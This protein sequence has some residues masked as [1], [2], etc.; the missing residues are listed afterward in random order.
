MA[1]ASP[2]VS[3]S[4]VDR[5]VTKLAIWNQPARAATGAPSASAE[6]LLKQ[7]LEKRGT[8][9]YFSDPSVEFKCQRLIGSPGSFSMVA[10]ALQGGRAPMAGQC[11]STIPGTFAAVSSGLVLIDDF[12]IFFADSTK[13]FHQIHLLD[14]AIVNSEASP[15]ELI[16]ECQSPFDSSIAAETLSRR[17]GDE[18]PDPAAGSGA[19]DAPPA[20]P[21]APPGTSINGVELP[22]GG[23]SVPASQTT[24]H[25]FIRF[26]PG[27]CDPFIRV[28]LERFYAVYPSSPRLPFSLEVTPPDRLAVLKAHLPHGDP[29]DFA[30]SYRASCFRFPKAL[31]PLQSH[32]L[33]LGTLAAEEAALAA[34]ELAHHAAQADSASYLDGSE[35]P[36]KLSSAHGHPLLRGTFRMGRF[37]RPDLD[38]DTVHDHMAALLWSLAYSRRWSSLTFGPDPSPELHLAAIHA[39]G[40]QVPRSQFDPLN[41]RLDFLAAAGA[42][43]GPAV[44]SSATTSDS[45]SFEGLGASIVAL[46]LGASRTL[47]MAS[48]F[49]PGILSSDGSEGVASPDHQNP[50]ALA[51]E[52]ATS[53]PGAPLPALPLRTRR[54]R[55][56]GSSSGSGLNGA[57]AREKAHAAYLPLS[58]LALDALAQLMALGDRTPFAYIEASR[59]GLTVDPVELLAGR[60]R[61]LHPAVDGAGSSVAIASGGGGG[62]GGSGGGGVAAAV[63][64]SPSSSMT[65]FSP[66]STS[67]RVSPAD[68]PTASELHSLDLSG[69]LLCDRALTSL[70]DYL[71]TCGISLRGLAISES[72][73]NPRGRGMAALCR[74][75]LLLQ[76]A[77]LTRL[78]LRSIRLDRYVLSALSPVLRAAVNLERLDIART[79]LKLEYVVEDFSKGCARS[80]KYLDISENETSCLK[81]LSDII[82]H[83]ENL[84]YLDMS[85]NPLSLDSLPVFIRYLLVNPCLADVC[86]VLRDVGLNAE[87]AELIFGLIS[88][89][90]VALDIS[91]NFLG[92]AGLEAVAS[93]LL[94][95]SSS[96]RSLVMDRCFGAAH[97]PGEHGR[98]RFGP[99]TGGSRSGAGPPAP[100]S[101]PAQLFAQMLRSCVASDRSDG[102]ATA[103]SADVTQGPCIERLSM[104]GD[105]GQSSGRAGACCL[106][107][108]LVEAIL[109]ALRFN[110]S[111]R[112]V[113]LSGHAGEDAA[114]V[115]LVEVLKHNSTLQSVSLDNNGSTMLGFEKLLTALE[116]NH[117]LRRFPLPVQDILAYRAAT[118][119]AGG[120]GGQITT[121][122]KTIH[123]LLLRNSAQG[124]SLVQQRHLACRSLDRACV[125]RLLL[126]GVSVRLCDDSLAAPLAM[127]SDE[128]D[129]TPLLARQTAAVLCTDLSL[130]HVQLR[131][132]GEWSTAPLLSIPVT[133]LREVT[134]L[135]VRTLRPT[136]SEDSAGPGPDIVH[137]VRIDIGPASAATSSTG[138]P[139]SPVS[140]VSPA[141]PLPASVL[142]VVPGVSLQADVV[143]LLRR[144]RDESDALHLVLPQPGAAARARATSTSTS[145]AT[146]QS[147]RYSILQSAAPR[148]AEAIDASV[149]FEGALAS[150]GAP[151]V[152]R[153]RNQDLI[154]DRRH[155]IRLL[156][157]ARASLLLGPDTM[158]S[159]LHTPPPLSPVSPSSAGAGP[160]AARELPNWAMS[161]LSH[162]EQRARLD[163]A[164]PEAEPAAA[165]AHEQRAD[166]ASDFLRS[167]RERIQDYIPPVSAPRTFLYTLKGHSVVRAR[168]IPEL[169]VS[170]LNEGDA[171]VLIIESQPAAATS[172]PPAGSQSSQYRAFDANIY[173]WSGRRASRRERDA[174][175]LFARDVALQDYFSANIITVSD[176]TAEFWQTL[177]GR[178]ADVTSEYDAGL[179]A[180]EE[181][182]WTRAYTLLRVA[183]NP[184]DSDHASGT[185]VE[186]V[187]ISADESAQAASGRLRPSLDPGAAYVLDTEAGEVF[188]WVG[189]R[190]PTVLRVTAALL[191]VD[192]AEAFVERRLFKRAGGSR[193]A[194]VTAAGVSPTRQPDSRRPSIGS[195]DSDHEVNDRSADAPAGT[196]SNGL[197]SNTCFATVRSEV[198]GR[199]SVFWRSKF[200]DWFDSSSLLS[201]DTLPQIREHV[202]VLATFGQADDFVVSPT[203]REAPWMQLVPGRRAGAGSIQ[204]DSHSA[205]ISLASA[206]GRVFLVDEVEQKSLDVTRDALFEGVPFTT[207]VPPP[208]LLLFSEDCLFF[209]IDES[210]LSPE[211]TLILWQGSQTTRFKRKIARG[212]IN[213]FQLAGAL[214]R[215][216]I[217]SQFEEPNWFTTFIGRPLVYRRG[218]SHPRLTFRH[219]PSRLFRVPPL[220]AGTSGSPK[221]ASPGSKP[222]IATATAAAAAA[223][224]AATTSTT[225][226]ANAVDPLVTVSAGPHAQRQ[227]SL[228]QH[229]HWLS[230][231]VSTEA[232]PDNTP[233]TAVT[234][235]QLKPYLAGMRDLAV[236]A[237]CHWSALNSRD[238]FI[239]QAR[240]G[241][242]AGEVGG[243]G[244][245]AGPDRTAFTVVWA[246]SLASPAEVANA[247]HI[248][249]AM[250]SSAATETISEPPGPDG[251][252]P[253][254]ATP[255]MAAAWRHFCHYLG[256][257]TDTPVGMIGRPIPA[258]PI[259]S[260]PTP[261]WPVLLEIS[262]PNL[263]SPYINLE[264]L[265][266]RTFHQ[267]DL[268]PDCAYIVDPAV[269]SLRDVTTDPAPGE[270]A[271][272]RPGVF[273]WIGPMCPAFLPP[274]PSVADA[275]SSPVLES[276][277]LTIG[278][279]SFELLVRVAAE[280]AS[281]VGLDP[282]AG[283]TVVLAGTE[284]S[285]FSAH[286][287]GW[288]GAYT[289][290]PDAVAHSNRLLRYDLIVK[291][292]WPA[293]VAVTSPDALELLLPER[294]LRQLLLA[295]HYWPSTGVHRRFARL[296]DWIRT[297]LKL[298]LELQI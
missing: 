129:I 93:S 141:A 97:S 201:L 102:A 94:A 246:G 183:A 63:G 117:T 61:L 255:R 285:T 118:R 50:T 288:S 159:A 109:P 88:H 105:Y 41:T 200:D 112:A 30:L 147:I 15:N 165:S 210:A 36:G 268:R 164:D 148:S 54:H 122:W 120:V 3:S 174:A 176:D 111:L 91:D 10:Q 283:V 157:G 34:A 57:T 220:E 295:P 161:V 167:L 213:E 266:V 144:L 77:N 12:N 262:F 206:Q 286:F 140:P 280:Y 143:A 225:T 192:R 13:I 49:S 272:P 115:A 273:L 9:E 153:L 233:V 40:G 156:A 198:S 8:V 83:C 103:P 99:G 168:L 132:S 242:L 251:K 163:A 5:L 181:G 56:L 69:N 276:L 1:A 31:T 104:R 89:N 241:S 139:L 234:L 208:P 281:H 277:G 250:G 123:S 145:V 130:E 196:P 175:R 124:S 199:E 180:V 155:T 166:A 185:V 26:S 274:V 2:S 4:R 194:A 11:S 58:P 173:V 37:W 209:Y 219:N 55:A 48:S 66:S 258:P 81:P 247:Q 290:G 85:H 224:A 19:A 215:L 289:P 95:G 160:G 47:A 79:R 202:K 187:A 248:A 270:G 195:I 239:L 142:V 214:P 158:A 23:G 101:R 217:I 6:D 260:R 51:A 265:P 74:S 64:M 86:L 108:D 133:R 271:P 68:G 254:A 43:G 27:M 203:G 84:K 72:V 119:G 45:T 291:R 267:R 238:C 71:L 204:T 264:R 228:T 67:A 211:R 146:R 298:E 100:V 205:G 221:T 42:A 232:G 17:Q 240:V 107:Q 25:V 188:T 39:Q 70:A 65:F 162:R 24:L 53:S 169:S 171:F 261:L 114:L 75:L 29:A 226:A 296:P 20:G 131:G 177:H 193:G 76:P 152:S 223:A 235:Y 128:E 179:D 60:A 90:I 7:E 172:V 278:S 52:E 230:T 62:G 116:T 126:A 80:L 96:L 38:L 222:M 149:S 243:P 106:R 113:D 259:P 287:A 21:D 125:R 73:T 59:V 82:Q 32:L 182:A 189:P 236:E 257:D 151:N 186:R 46:A 28:L 35:V 178:R 135:T 294:T 137:V 279:C 245:G 78:E 136:S 154:R 293:G 110:Q 282:R 33:V 216:F 263:A 231:L 197:A 252:L 87:T 121:T 191:A 218:A 18:D 229:L 275:G 127:V 184:S 16:L 297:N 190:T 249:Q 256:L 14:V 150:S 212:L 170:R 207:G 138:S 98:M 244:A 269:R 134:P 227:A 292:P 253:V 44:S 22:A 284:P 92:N 237:D